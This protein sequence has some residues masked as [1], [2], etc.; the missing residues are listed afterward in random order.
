MQSP[1]LGAGPTLLAADAIPQ[2]ILAKISNDKTM[3]I[4]FI[5]FPP[6]LI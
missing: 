5:S 6:F 3:Q 4:F 1:E 2:I